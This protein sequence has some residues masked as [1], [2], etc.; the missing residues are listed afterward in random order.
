M[1]FNRNKSLANAQK[2]LQ[3]GKTAEAIKLYQEVVDNDPS[4]VRTLLKVGDLQ[5]KIGNVGEAN[6]TYRRVAEHYAKDGFFLK[7]VAVFKQI[8]K[9]DPGLISVYIRLAEL[10]QQLGLNSEAMKQYQT[11]VRHYENQG[12]K[13]ESLDILKKM[14]ELEPDNIA[15]RVK[16]A[17]LYARE[18]HQ[19]EAK[20]QF[21]AVI[22]DL[23]NK[24]NLQDLSRVYEKVE[25]LKLAEGPLAL[26]LIELYLKTSEPK[27]ALER[28][29]EL[30]KNDPKN[31]Q[32]LELLARTFAELQQPEKAR[33]VYKELIGIH[34]ASGN[35]GEKE[36]ISARLRALGA[37]ESAAAPL[38]GMPSPSTPAPKVAP[39]ARPV[40][41]E[42]IA[43]QLGEAQ[44]LLQYGLLEKACDLLSRIVLS[45]PSH[46]P[47]RAKLIET[48]QSKG[49][50][51]GL[52]DIL[53]KAVAIVEVQGD[54][55]TIDAIRIEIAQ[56][57][58]GSP[59]AASETVVLEPEVDSSVS[60]VSM[61]VSVSDEIS[62][63]IVDDMV[64][65]PVAQ[66]EVAAPAPAMTAEPIVES[67]AVIDFG[68]E[69]E[70]SDS[71]EMAPSLNF[72]VSEIIEEPPAKEEE[73]SAAIVEKAAPEPVADMMEEEPSAPT[74]DISLLAPE[75][76]PVEMP[77][78]EIAPEV[79][80]ESRAFRRSETDELDLFSSD[81]EE[82]EYFVQQ[83][84]LDEAREVYENI[85]RQ[86]SSYEPARSKLEELTGVAK[87][88]A[89]SAKKP[90]K[91]ATV[92]PP[93]RTKSTE[94]VLREAAAASQP[95]GEGFFDLSTE[96]QEEISELEQGLTSEKSP[97][98]EEYLSPEE[99]I[100][101]FK[102]G[103]AR[104]VAKD[105]YQTH[106][107]LGIAY[108]EMGLLDEAIHEFDI[109]A[110]DKKIAIDCA[111]MVGHCLVGKREY[112][113]AIDVYRRALA[114][115]S[116]QSAEAL[117]L[118]YELAEAYIGYG[119][120]SDAYKLFARI[121]DADPTFRD[122]RRRAKE[123]EADLGS[124]APPPSA[125]EK[126][127]KEAVVDISK[128]KTKIT[129]I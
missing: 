107:N 57:S 17:E 85:L 68:L 47:S 96:L 50:P 19:K 69:F 29:Q 28:L 95:E 46:S 51:I 60:D 32:V 38:T 87:P 115:V 30:F 71:E 121:R 117:G 86:Q 41:S 48:F 94:R 11:V 90:A 1:A 52:V 37:S 128:K 40:S 64:S 39:S 91:L 35:S 15:S 89:K 109:A 78:S 43:K 67:E 18:G 8:L 55:A 92:S 61:D 100:S 45:N 22:T 123:L 31:P 93:K 2:A 111:S 5:A 101:E 81:M 56:V 116:P 98:E 97:E 124:S 24:N 126:R 49:D 103:V 6:D 74:I 3:K 21:Q 7:A 20:D 125:P 36:K 66:E 112:D 76:A 73:L 4:D 42:G 75:P 129:Y 82:A 106:Y 120:L 110:Q 99:V 113:T 65:P 9:L 26:D 83:G 72:D 127:V 53:T 59:P 108:K 70:R 102:K 27:R 118:S 84:L 114:R 62:L 79:L 88:A 63:E 13:K 16:L 10:Y 54:R 23:K 14:A 44:V 104:T 12:L 105:D 34:E 80:E 77:A 58:G 25:A 119:N 33:S 122:V